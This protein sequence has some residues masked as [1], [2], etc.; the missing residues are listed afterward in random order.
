[1]TINRAADDF[2]GGVKMS[3]AG[4][5]AGDT[6]GQPTV[7]AFLAEDLAHSPAVLLPEVAAANTALSAIARGT[8]FFETYGRTQSVRDLVG[9]RLC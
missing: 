7:R 9:V 6:I 5:S 3:V 2:F 4:T 8:H 1:M